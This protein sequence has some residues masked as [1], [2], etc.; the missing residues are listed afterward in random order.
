MRHLPV[1]D[2]M[3]RAVREMICTHCFMRPAGSEALPPDI[4]R[5]CQSN[6]TIFMNLPDLR[7]IAV[8]MSD[9]RP[10]VFERAIR[11]MICSKCHH[12]MSA[13]DYCAEHLAE[14]CPLSV[15]GKL[16]LETLDKIPAATDA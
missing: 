8:E 9:Q 2:V 15:Y 14:T 16:V 10:G 5:D 12:C 4:P 11:N 7:E 6:C 3:Q 1:L 13:G